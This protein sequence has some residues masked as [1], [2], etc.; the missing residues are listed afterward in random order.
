MNCSLCEHDA[1]ILKS[2][3]FGDICDFC[4]SYLMKQGLVDFELPLPKKRVKRMRR[5]RVQMWADN[6]L[7]RICHKKIKSLRSSSIDHRIPLSMGGPRW[8]LRNLQL[9]HKQCNNIKGNRIYKRDLILFVVFF[10]RFREIHKPLLSQY[11]ENKVIEM[12]RK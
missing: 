8:D 5:I 9:A 2:S 11:L 12:R 6:N 7:C 3:E 1:N 10:R 4:E